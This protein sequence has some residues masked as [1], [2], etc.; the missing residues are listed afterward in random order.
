[1]VKITL[2]NNL[3]RMHPFSKIETARTCE[4]IRS[5]VADKS[6]KNSLSDDLPMLRTN[7][8]QANNEIIAGGSCNEIN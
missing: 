3:S 5:H 8:G 4:G 6:I 1:M 7:T 2:D